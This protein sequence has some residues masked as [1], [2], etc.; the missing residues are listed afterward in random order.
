[1]ANV[2]VSNRI[3]NTSNI[4][5][6]CNEN[7]RLRGLTD[8]CTARRQ[9]SANDFY[10]FF[11]KIARS[12]QAVA[13]RCRTRVDAITEQ[14]IGRFGQLRT[15]VVERRRRWHSRRQADRVRDAKDCFFF[16]DF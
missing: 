14:T 3:Y 12:L 8:K 6:T 15:R 16:G 13:R 9:L 5:D 7:V 10:I 2:D 4:A 1:M 11:A